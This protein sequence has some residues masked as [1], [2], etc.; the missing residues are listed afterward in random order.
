MKFAKGLVIAI[1]FAA[2]GV[3][4]CVNGYEDQ[5]KHLVS[6]PDAKAVALEVQRL[7]ASYQ[8]QSTAEIANDF[9]VVLLLAGNTQRAID[10]LMR[11]EQDK[12][13]LANTASNLGTALELAGRNREAMRWIQEGIKRNPADHQGTEWVHVK[14]LEAK[15][16]I[17]ADPVWL[18]THTVLGLQFGA[19]D[20]PQKPLHEAIDFLGQT[21]ALRDAQSAVSYQ[22]QERLKFVSPPDAVVAD[23]LASLGNIAY[24][25]GEESPESYYRRAIDFGALD[26]PALQRRVQ[27][28]ETHLWGVSVVA[29]RLMAGLAIS[30]GAYYLWTQ[31]SRRKTKSERLAAGS[32][33]AQN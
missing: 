16:A 17:E 31:R 30:G 1:L 18:K 2:N 27:Y 29:W 21:R 13:G 4:A 32:S 11:L 28:I 14:I 22:L 8:Q 20:L 12:P 25:L 10:V 6:K 7:E 24:T 3:L 26:A 15:L 19:G 33:S 5:T 9:A 23:L